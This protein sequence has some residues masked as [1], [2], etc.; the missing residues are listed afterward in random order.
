MYEIQGALYCT[1][2]PWVCCRRLK[3]SRLAGL[4]GPA[5]RASRAAICDGTPPMDY[6]AEEHTGAPGKV[7]KSNRALD[8]Q[9]VILHL[10][11]FNFKKRKAPAAPSAPQAPIKTHKHTQKE[12]PHRQHISAFQGSTKHTI[13]QSTKKELAML[14]T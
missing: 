2:I 12:Q 13:K 1:Y 5:G 4:A 11:N 8:R 10:K 7:K 3:V 14:K 6:P 9:W